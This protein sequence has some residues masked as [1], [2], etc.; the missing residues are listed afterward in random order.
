GVGAAG[1]ELLL[2]AG[3]EARQDV[4]RLA[5]PADAHLEPLPGQQ[6]AGKH[7]LQPV[8]R[9]N[10]IDEIASPAVAADL[11]LV[12]LI[13]GDELFLLFLIGLEEEAA[14]LVERATQ[15]LEQ[16]AHAAG[17]KPSTEGLLDPLAGLSRTLE[18]SG[19]DLLLELVELASSQ[20]AGVAFVLQRTQGIE[21]VAL[22]EGQPVL[23]GTRADAQPRSDLL[24]RIA[25][26]QPQQGG[27]AI[28]NPCL[29]LVAAKLFDTPLSCYTTAL[30]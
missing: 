9:V 28:M 12:L 25:V 19:G 5:A 18:A 3:A 1:V 20:S 7:H 8:K 23:D 24:S 4:Q 26:R 22:V 16:F 17:R 21:S 30:T 2:V 29:L 6:P 10:P 27:K 14:H 11:A 13:F 15:A